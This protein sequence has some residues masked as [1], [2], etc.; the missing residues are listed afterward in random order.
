MHCA[1]RQ[2]APAS[3]SKT[4][5]NLKRKVQVTMMHNRRIS[6]AK[7]SSEIRKKSRIRITTP[8]K[9][10]SSTRKTLTVTIIKTIRMKRIA[11]TRWWRVRVIKMSA[12]RASSQLWL[13]APVLRVAHNKQKSNKMTQMTTT[14]R[15]KTTYLI[16]RIKIC[17][18][19][20]SI[21]GYITRTLF[22]RTA[23][24]SY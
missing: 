23:Y 12:R 8:N 14:Q 5:R 10:I 1:A 2:M 11:T 19:T 22:S 16:T 20:K 24:N 18:S 13:M 9:I 4:P 15:K 3:L 21:V 7:R 17:T 6:I